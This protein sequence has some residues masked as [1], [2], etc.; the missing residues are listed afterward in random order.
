LSEKAK[1]PSKAASAVFLPAMIENRPKDAGAQRRLALWYAAQGENQLAL[2]HF[3]LALEMNPGDAQTI[4]DVGSAYFELGKRREADEY[5]SK[6]IA[7]DS[8]KIEALALY[9]RTLA[10]NGL[11][12]EARTKLRPLVINHLAAANRNDEKMESLKP[13]IRAL[14]RSFNKESG[15]EGDGGAGASPKD[16]AEKD[17]FL[18]ELCGSAPGNLA[19]PEMAI[20]EPLVKREHFAPFYEALIRRTEGVARYES[21]SDFV[22]R[23]RRRS[24]W[25]LDEIEESL[26][27]ERASQ[28]TTR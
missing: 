3:Q 20:N 9:L 2:E 16:E 1:Q 24:S 4:A 18:R 12:P 6:I 14:A 10:K 19:L 23:L 21:D 22:D 5:W 27:H 28:P 25:S 11:A 8:P 26:D 17:A 7:D 13:L 15:K